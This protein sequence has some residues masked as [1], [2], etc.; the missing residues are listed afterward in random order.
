MQGQC[1]SIRTLKP[2]LR[3][4]GYAGHLLQEDI[5]LGD[6]CVAPLVGF[7]HRPF[8]ARSACITVIQGNGDSAAAVGRYRHLGA[9][10]VF[11][12]RQ[13]RLEWWKQG[14]EHPHRLQT[15]P[16]AQVAGFFEKHAAE[17][18][19]KKVYR[20][21]AWASVNRGYQL[22][23]V[24]LGLMPLVEAEV[25]DHLTRLIEHVV[26]LLTKK[27]SPS[28]A[29]SKPLG[30]W[31]LRSA[32]WLVAAK[33]LKDK[34]V[35][36]FC[37]LDLL[38]V[39]RVLQQVAGHYGEHDWTETYS[40]PKERALREAAQV[41]AEFSHLGHVTTESLSYIYESALVEK[42]VRQKLGIHST[43]PCLVDY[44]M[45]RLAPWI[46]AM[47][48]EERYV[49]EPACGHS[50]FLV[51]AMRL[52]RELL[53]KRLRGEEQRKKYLRKHLC[54]VEVDP[55][56]IEIARLSVTLADIPNPNGW[57]LKC[58]DMFDGRVLEDHAAKASILLANPPFASFKADERDAYAKHQAPV[59]YVNKAAEMLCRTLPHL[60]EGA[61][62][63]VVVPQGFLHSR[64]ARELRKYMV[65]HFEI[66][67]I[68]LFP[69]K[70]FRFS[71]M[72]SA[73]V[74]GRKRL[75][76]PQA[77]R[78]THY[79]RVRE[80]D[81]QKFRGG[82]DITWRI[83]VPTQ[84]FVE[85][86]WNLQVPDLAEVW[87]WCA[88]LPRLHELA[89]LGKGLDYRGKDD[90]PRKA[91]TIAEQGFEGAVAGYAVVGRDSVIHDSPPEVYM[92]L[93][94]D[95]VKTA[96]R[97]TTTGRPQVILNYARVSRGP[98]RLKAFADDQ[99]HAVT[100]RFI[101][102]RPKSPQVPIEYLWALF[103]SPLANAYAYAH[104]RK[105]DILVGVMR[106]L[107]VPRASEVQMKRVVEAARAYLHAARPAARV[108]RQYPNPKALHQLLLRMDA[109]VLRLY[110]LP[111]RM[112]REIL[113]LF[114]SAERPGVPPGFVR[115]FP[116]DFTPCFHLHEYLSEDY[117]RS[118]AGELSKRLTPRPPPAFLAALDRA[119]AAFK[120]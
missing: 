66:A 63:G 19:P 96:R 93:A 117:K 31:L 98:W 84:L 41:V 106:Q 109:E 88:C 9:P 33:I 103:N 4:C 44:V 16:A 7:A 72:E 53:P 97:G 65:S 46:E 114:S 35:R 58:R 22:S 120:E 18:A 87:E 3:Q 38:D 13:A 92:S 15:I 119:V 101:V 86:D 48:A 57:Q 42:A 52:L 104:L 77:A 68:C 94:K 39:K 23:F 81:M 40:G 62:F 67:D 71:D 28:G 108:L 36:G 74:L 95:V 83:S 50:A 37:T 29:P 21:K 6:D 1:L 112:E 49:F 25:G 45:G 115:Y 10:V 11:V 32:F 60:R 110:N 61:V 99:G 69:D 113:D 90:L 82:H 47:P 100:S 55:F 59:T 105:R 14:H 107:P 85:R 75:I 12:L 2:L 54:G 73:V 118:T 102:V 20:A 111:A 91:R 8:D 5:W 34:R 89:D 51:A 76:S 56:A 26:R 43:P 24:D 64:N 27:L 17:L 30:Q 70:M 78:E 116:K 80:A 79:A